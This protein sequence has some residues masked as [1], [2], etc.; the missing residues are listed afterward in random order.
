MRLF[1]RLRTRDDLH[2]QP[3]DTHAG[4]I[5][6][7]DRQSGKQTHQDPVK[8]IFLRAARAAG[9]AEHRLTTRL[10]DQHQVARID[11]HAEVFDVTAYRFDGRRD[12]VAAIGYRGSAKNDDELGAGLEQFVDCACQRGLIVRHSLLGDDGRTGWRNARGG[13]LQGLFD[14]FW[15]KTGQQRGH[16]ADLAQLVGRDTNDRFGFR[17]RGHRLVARGFRHRKRND[18]YGRDHFA[19]DHRLVGRQRRQ[20]DRLVDAVERVDRIPIDNQNSGALGKQIAATCESPIDAHALARNRRCN[21]GRRLI[22]RDIARVETRHGNFLHARCL[23]RRHFGRPDQRPFLE[24]E[25][26]LADRMHRGP[27]TASATGTEPNFMPP[28][29]SAAAP[30]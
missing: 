1:A 23:E 7:R 26:A 21:V 13:N 24:D 9:S 22:F 6:A 16:H 18:L 8:T 4:D 30:A 17:R 29:P 10:A 2:Q 28:P 5:R 12:D 25:I 11:R 15:S 19:F 27:P 20:R 14:D 3:A